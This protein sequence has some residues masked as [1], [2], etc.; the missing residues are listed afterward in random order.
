[1]LLQVVFIAVFFNVAYSAVQGTKQSTLAYHCGDT[2]TGNV[3]YG[4]ANAHVWIFQT[5]DAKVDVTFSTCNSAADFTEG[6]VLYD[7]K[8][9]ESQSQYIADCYHSTGIGCDTC[10]LTSLTDWTVFDLGGDYELFYIEIYS[11][12]TGTNSYK[13]EITCIDAPTTPNP[14]TSQP[15]T[16][17]PTT[18]TPTATTATPTTLQP[19]TAIP[20]T[21]IPTTSMPTTVIPTTALPTTTM[22][23]T[24][25]P[26]TS[27]P[28]T[29]IPTAIPTTT[30][31]TT[32]APTTYQPTT[33]TPTT[34][35]PTN[36]P[37]TAIPTSPNLV[38]I[39]TEPPTTAADGEAK[40]TN[41]NTLETG[42]AKT[43]NTKSGMDM[44]TI[45]LI[46]IIALVVIILCGALG[47]YT[48]F[49]KKKKAAVVKENAA[50][51]IEIAQIVPNDGCKTGTG[52]ST[53]TDSN[54]N[55]GNTIMRVGSVSLSG[56]R[57]NI[58]ITDMGINK[59]DDTD[60]DTD[61]EMY[62]KDKMNPNI[63]ESPGSFEITPGS[64]PTAGGIGADFMDINEN[65][66][67]RSN[68]SIGSDEGDILNED[69]NMDGMYD[70][71]NKYKTSGKDD[72]ND[73]EMYKKSGKITKS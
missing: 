32:N 39:P 65:D 14:T 9:D 56:E 59:D 43:D 31:P 58:M 41:S 28:T 18:N 36:T 71:Q 33:T 46:V 63:N 38:D 37:T 17:I 5:Y 24:Y 68:G 49:L 1:M 34:N 73:D 62:D 10:G 72:V 12:S 11:V 23:T 22:P 25:Q 54:T 29:Q 4:N 55:N 47:C 6:L 44:V 7:Y 40:N 52:T 26:T 57:E 42:D 66:N 16:A 45:L 35:A 67:N 30:T 50:N 53:G 21:N 2:I 19:T 8:V 70:K 51:D 20:T 69:E 60:T 3:P 15:T 48:C 27:N 61:N 64:K 13:I